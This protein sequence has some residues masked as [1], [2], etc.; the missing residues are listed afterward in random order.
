MSTL[1]LYTPINCDDYEHLE[2]ACERHWIL[3]LQLRN[4]EQFDAKAE[5][6]LMRKQVEY[7]LLSESGQSREVRLD[8]I[9]RFTHPE[10]GTVIININ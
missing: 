6:L 3:K 9:D 8:K 10:L 1:E 2:Q 7:L 4:G 5:S